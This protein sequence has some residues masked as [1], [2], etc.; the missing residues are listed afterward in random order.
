VVKLFGVI[1]LIQ[2]RDGNFVTQFNL[3]MLKNVQERN[4]QNT[5]VIRIRLLVEEL[6]WLG[7]N[8]VHTS[9]AEPHRNIQQVVLEI[10]TSV[11]TQI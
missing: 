4:V 1:P 7:P 5:E 3:M 6:V 2:R 11:E 9:I 8:R 10:T